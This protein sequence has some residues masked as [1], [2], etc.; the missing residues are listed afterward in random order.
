MNV[1]ARRARRAEEAEEQE[2]IRNALQR[3]EAAEGS[4]SARQNTDVQRQ[5]RREELD[6][7]MVADARAW[8]F[9]QRQVQDWEQRNI[10]WR[11]FK[12][13][14]EGRRKKKGRWSLYGRFG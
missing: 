7:A 10:S 9:F 13:R 2:R 1:A 12:E 4:E 3:A 14:H 6:A 11:A 5:R 8:D